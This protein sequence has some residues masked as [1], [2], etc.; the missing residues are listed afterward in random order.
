[1]QITKIGRKS[2]CLLF[3]EMLPIRILIRTH[4]YSG[5]NGFHVSHVFTDAI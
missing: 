1:M 2:S 4:Y 3:K 5:D